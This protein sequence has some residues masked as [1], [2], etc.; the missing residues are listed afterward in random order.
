MRIL[1]DIKE[2][3]N[4]HSHSLRLAAKCEMCSELSID[5]LLLTIS[6]LAK[7]NS[8]VFSSIFRCLYKYLCNF[9]VI[10]LLYLYNNVNATT[11]N[12]FKCTYVHLRLFH[13]K[14]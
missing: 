9:H 12:K 14:L 5:F 2:I 7:S 1:I 6:N 8:H 11:R 3:E 4:S 13:S 10:S